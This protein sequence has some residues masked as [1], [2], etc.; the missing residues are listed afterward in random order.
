[1]TEKRGEIEGGEKVSSFQSFSCFSPPS[2][3]S[4]KQN[5]SRI[6]YDPA[7]FSTKN[8]NICSFFLKKK[9][10]ETM[11]KQLKYLYPR[12]DLTVRVSSELYK[13]IHDCCN[14]LSVSVQDVIACALLTSLDSAAVNCPDWKSLPDCLR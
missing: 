9:G 5:F 6:F 1:M 4:A 13:I 2:E 10:S 11:R 14:E 8:A 7:I 12:T 3:T